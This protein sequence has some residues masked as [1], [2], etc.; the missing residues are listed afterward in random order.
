M[1]NTLIASLLLALSPAL[2]LA[3][4]VSLAWNQ[5]DGA[6]PDGYIVERRAGTGIYAKIDTTPAL[7]YT[8]TTVPTVA[9]VC[10]QIRAYNSLFTT[11]P[12]NEICLTRPGVPIN[13]T[14]A[15]VG[16]T[17]SA[18]PARVSVGVRRQKR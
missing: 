15:T 8:D 1:R 13:F 3:A 12:S 14:L 2:A 16:P 6:V 11:E 5:G 4:S 10:Y 18:A 7:T 17:A 9:P